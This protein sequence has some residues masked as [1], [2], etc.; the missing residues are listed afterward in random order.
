M[1]QALAIFALIAMYGIIAYSIGIPLPSPLWR[2]FF[3]LVAL[4]GVLLYHGERVCDHLVGPV[5]KPGY[6]AEQNALLKRIENGRMGRMFV[7]LVTIGSGFS[8]TALF[9][10]PRLCLVGTSGRGAD[11][12]S[13]PGRWAPH[14]TGHGGGY[15]VHGRDPEVGKGPGR[16][17]VAISDRRRWYRRI[18]CCRTGSRSRARFEAMSGAGQAKAKTE[19]RKNTVL[20]C[21][22]ISSS[23][24]V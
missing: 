9:S 5:T 16:V 18:R 20:C 12:R 19:A 14:F 21:N 4:E 15:R 1:R 24:F 8:M 7:L 6:T 13:H 3:A 2:W 11:V 22:V 23:Q 17:L 10:L